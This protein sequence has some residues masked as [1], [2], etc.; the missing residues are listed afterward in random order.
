MTPN[1]VSKATAPLPILSL[2]CEAAQRLG[3]SGV[4]IM[5]EGPLEWD[6]VRSVC[7]GRFHLRGHVLGAADGGR[8]QGRPPGDRGRAH[9]GRDRRANHPGL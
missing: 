2:A 5:P 8:P 3:A 9:R 4:V 7:A 1:L 6:L